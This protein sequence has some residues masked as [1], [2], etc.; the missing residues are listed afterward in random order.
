MTDKVLL[1]KTKHWIIVEN[2]EGMELEEHECSVY[3]LLFQREKFCEVVFK[4]KEKL[5]VILHV[6]L[7]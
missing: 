1:E 7:Y 6:Q 2:C 3:S 5:R 4:T